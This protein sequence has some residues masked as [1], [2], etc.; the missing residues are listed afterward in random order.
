MERRKPGFAAGPSVVVQRIVGLVAEAAEL[1]VEARSD[2]GEV[3]LVAAIVAEGRELAVDHGSA[4]VADAHHVAAPKAVVVAVLIE[5]DEQAFD[6]EGQVVGEGVL[7]TAAHR[8]AEVVIV[9]VIAEE[10]E[11]AVGRPNE[12]AR[13][14]GARVGEEAG[15]DERSA[16]RDAG[17]EAAKAVEVIA[18]VVVLKR[19]T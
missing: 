2:H 7:K 12:A 15:S 18:V 11:A 13:K 10:A 5:A 6:L 9:P 3:V 8:K 14:R 16:V 19:D 4:G 1:E 17:A